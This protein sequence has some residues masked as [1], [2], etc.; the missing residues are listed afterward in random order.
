MTWD[1]VL[2]KGEIAETSAASSKRTG[3]VNRSSAQQRKREV[4]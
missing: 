4:F 1:V 3:A 2:E